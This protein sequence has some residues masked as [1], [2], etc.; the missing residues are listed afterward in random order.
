MNVGW[1]IHVVQVL[2]G[3]ERCLAAIVTAINPNLTIETTVF[4]PHGSGIDVAHRVS[5][6]ERWHLLENCD[7]TP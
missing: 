3:Q 4:T 6:P 7:A 2:D 5:K 1:S